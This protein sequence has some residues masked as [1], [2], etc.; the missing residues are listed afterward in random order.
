MQ[1]HQLVDKL[2]LVAK[3]VLLRV[4]ASRSA[5]ASDTPTPPSVIRGGYSGYRGASAEEV[6]GGRGAAV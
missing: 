2:V 4:K 5:S 6:K 1:Q 3:I